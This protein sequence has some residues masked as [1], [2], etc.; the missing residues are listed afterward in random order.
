LAAGSTW[1]VCE[2]VTTTNAC[3]GGMAIHSVEI[4]ANTLGTTAGKNAY[5]YIPGRLILKVNTFTQS[6]VGAGSAN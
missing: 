6:V 4:A 2:V 1:N 3:N 5:R